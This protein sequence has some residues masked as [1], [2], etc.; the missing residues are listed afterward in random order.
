M[1]ASDLTKQK[2]I[3]YERAFTEAAQ[4]AV[5]TVSQT[6]EIIR[7]DNVYNKCLID[8]IDELKI[9]IKE[10]SSLEEL[11]RL[12]SEFYKLKRLVE[13]SPDLSCELHKLENEVD[14]LLSYDE[15]NTEVVSHLQREVS[16]TE[17]EIHKLSEHLDK[18][19]EKMASEFLIQT[20]MIV[21][22]D[23]KNQSVNNK[24]NERI[25][26][27]SYEVEK[28]EHSV[29]LLEAKDNKDQRVDQILAKLRDFVSKNELVEL[30]E[31]LACIEKKKILDERVDELIRRIRELECRD[32]KD[33][34][35]EEI[36]KR[37]LLVEHREMRDERFDAVMEILSDVV[38]K[39]EL[40]KLRCEVAALAAKK[41]HDERV[42]QI[43]SML[44]EFQTVKDAVKMKLRLDALEA[45][46][47]HDERFDLLMSDMAKMKIKVDTLEVQNQV[48]SQVLNALLVKNTEQDHEI[49]CL[50]EKFNRS[51][52]MV[53]QK[54]DNVE[55][56]ALQ[57][58]KVD[59]DQ[60]ASIKFL[61]SEIF[62][63]KNQLSVLTRAA[64]VK[65]CDG[66]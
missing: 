8:A 4:K 28:L 46:K 48:Q 11:N 6:Q 17:C 39:K 2:E 13:S 49:Q 54:V 3:S 37:L 24:Q 63:L 40:E 19:D 21:D 31:R 20:K 64:Y 12:E 59:L 10:I 65:S 62:A 57:E 38:S 7:L 53:D 27:L 26:A 32:Y 51:L 29:L 61:Q 25:T 36:L 22:M 44:S 14:Q 42:D 56:H 66:K 34:R 5:F 33:L 35:I 43:L 9:K 41:F 30:L 1:S 58:E 45:R 18:T 16:E 23:S 50:N 60:N 52:I 15:K 55:R 47:I